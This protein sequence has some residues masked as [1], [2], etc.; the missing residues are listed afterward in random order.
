MGQLLDPAARA[1][2]RKLATQLR[3]I[4]QEQAPDGPSRSAAIRFMLWG[5]APLVRTLI[6]DLDDMSQYGAVDPYWVV[7]AARD[8]VGTAQAAGDE[9]DEEEEVEPSRS[10]FVS[11][12]SRDRPFSACSG[13]QCS[14][15]L[16][17]PLHLQATC[18]RYSSIFGTIIVTEYE[19]RLC[20][21]MKKDTR[22]TVPS[23]N[24]PLETY[25]SPHNHP[26]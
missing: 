23:V 17:Q 5:M 21:E 25:L 22:E 26:T 15:S 1:E 24:H 12:T 11:Y 10:S 19:C 9:E 20:A 7:E 3:N 14:Q 6:V 4:H 2:V 16:G 8:L 13:R 18:P